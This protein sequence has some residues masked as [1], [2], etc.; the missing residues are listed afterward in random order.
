VKTHSGGGPSWI[1][2]CAS[3][4]PCAPRGRRKRE[5]GKGTRLGSRRLGAP[6]DEV[7]IEAYPADP[8][9]LSANMR[10]QT[11]LYTWGGIVLAAS[12]LAGA[13]S[14]W[15]EALAE[16]RE[17]GTGAISRPPSPTT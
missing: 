9:A 12:V 10:L 8:E 7:T 5:P 3:T 13:C 4:A 2:R 1:W 17:R 16:I 15:R 14:S 6:L 11:R